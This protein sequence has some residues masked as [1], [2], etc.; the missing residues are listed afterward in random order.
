MDPTTLVVVV[1]LISTIVGAILG[2]LIPAL[3]THKDKNAELWQIS[4]QKLYDQ[5]QE[6]LNAER[7]QRQ[8]DV[9]RIHMLIATGRRKDDY[10]V[11]LRQHIIDERP[12]PPPP[13]PEGLGD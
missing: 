1:G 4:Q 8:L 11:E 12:P 13:Y 9:E 6:D 7:K 5:L 2:S 3:F 10:I